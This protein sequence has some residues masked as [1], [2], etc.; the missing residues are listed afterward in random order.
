[1]HWLHLIIV[2]WPIISRISRK[3]RAKRPKSF[4]KLIDSNRPGGGG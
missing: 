4:S 1:M 3:G 2:I